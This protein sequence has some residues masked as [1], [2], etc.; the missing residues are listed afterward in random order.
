MIQKH[1]L[2]EDFPEFSE[3]IATLK[4]EDSHFKK[5]FE[6]YDEL[7]HQVY[8]VESESEPTTDERLNEL[9]SKRV[10]LKDEIYQYLLSL[11]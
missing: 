10:H 8:R 5:L 3:K 6:Q 2:V 1:P 4:I 11:N 7:D 9:R